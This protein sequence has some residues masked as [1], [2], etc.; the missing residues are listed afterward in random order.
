[1]T[2]DGFLTVLALGAA[3]Y[4]VLSPVQRLRLSLTWRPQFCLA[5]PSLAGILAFELFDLQPPSCPPSFG[6]FCNLLTLG[7]AD[8][9]P[10]RKF[11]FLIAFAWLIGAIVIHRI[12][13]PTLASV[14]AFTT[15]ATALIDEEQYGDALKLLEPHVR[16]LA[17]ASRRKCS[18]QRLHDWLDD[19]GPTPENSFKRFLRRSGER[20]F[21]GESWPGWAAAPVR[22]ISRW[23]PD[24]ARS[25]HAAADILQLIMTSPQ[26]FEYIVARRPYFALSLFRADIFGAPDFLERYLTE[27]MRRQGSALY[28]EIAT[29]DVCDGMIGYRLPSRNRILHYLFADARVAEE[30]S[31]WKGV[32][33]YLERLLDGDERPDYWSWLNDRPD[34]FDRD[35]MQDPTFVG[36]FFFSIM[37]SAAAKQGVGYHMWLYYIPHIAERLERGYNSSGDGIDQTAEFPTRSAHLLYDLFCHLTSWVEFFRHLPAGAEHR[38][39]PDRPGGAA[40]VPHASALSLGT[41]LFCVVMSDRIDAGVVRTLHDVTIRTIKNL[42][43]DDGE[44]SQMRAFLIEAL[45]SG[46]ERRPNR[47]YWTKLATLLDQN[48]DMIEYEIQDYVVALK[49]KIDGVRREA[50]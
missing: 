41:V 29:N 8:P 30:L 10:A 25:E 9:G 26:L 39:F 6:R 16:L 50:D 14:P 31:A 32:G 18:R 17:Q 12:A 20:R 40:T 5:M 36:M 47:R 15:V 44:V 27:L 48:D 13:K 7:G 1:M 21:S 23:I 3:I 49:A 46:G 38:K 2:L 11:A 35:Q 42:H 22:F 24:G 45:L 4:A 28:Q 33:N 37:V 43:P 19:F 34:W